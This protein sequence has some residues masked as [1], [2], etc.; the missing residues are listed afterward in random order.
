MPMSSKGSTLSTSQFALVVGRT[1][2]SGDLG[3]DTPANP[4]KNPSGA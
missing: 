4:P 2:R 1:R 3:G